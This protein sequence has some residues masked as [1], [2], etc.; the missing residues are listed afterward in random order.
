[1]FQAIPVREENIFAF[2]ATGK[3]TDA[4]Y[5]QFLPELT[6]LI[7]QYGPISLLVELEGFHGWEAKAV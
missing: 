6:S 1:M 2:K 5:Q 4:D 7:N 3:L